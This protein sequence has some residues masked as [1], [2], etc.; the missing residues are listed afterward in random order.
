MTRADAGWRFLCR[1]LGIHFGTPAEARRHGRP[2]LRGPSALYERPR[3]TPLVLG[4]RGRCLTSGDR[5]PPSARD[6][7]GGAKQI[8]SCRERDRRLGDR[9]RG[10]D[11]PL[12]RRLR[13]CCPPTSRRECVRACGRSP[14]QEIWRCS[15]GRQIRHARP[16][17]PP[18]RSRGSTTTVSGGHAAAPTTSRSGVRFC[19]LAR[20][21]PV[22]TSAEHCA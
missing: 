3:G 7:A 19:G 6:R 22:T 9:R 11:V 17:N 20:A 16:A 13:P 10:G 15:S 14:K 5:R 8:A 18:R 21:L 2:G 12:V 4:A 1:E